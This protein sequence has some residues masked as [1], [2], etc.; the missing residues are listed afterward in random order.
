MPKN[1]SVARAGRPR[2]TAV[3][4]SERI[5]RYKLGEKCA[6]HTDECID[7]WVRIMRNEPEIEMLDGNPRKV[8][9]GPNKGKQMYKRPYSPEQQLAASDRLMERAYGRAVTV[10][11][12]DQETRKMTMNKRIIEVRWLPPDPADTSKRIAPSED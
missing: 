6:E 4:I 5:E 2:F 11:D 9:N 7:L 12:V 3:G 8:L 1:L 10:M